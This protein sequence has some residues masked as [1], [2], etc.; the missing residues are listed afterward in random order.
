MNDSYP[1]QVNEVSDDKNVAAFFAIDSAVM[2]VSQ[3]ATSE[4][5]V[6][7]KRKRRTK[8]EMEAD[9]AAS[10]K[11]AEPVAAPVDEEEGVSVADKMI[12][13]KP[14]HGMSLYCHTQQKM[15]YAGFETL[16]LKDKW[17]ANQIRKG[18][19]VQV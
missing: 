18:V 13:V 9:R 5:P 4:P 14:R 2:T 7:V 12:R 19:L 16:I 1:A 6:P 17:I 10:V 15:I 11:A 3:G 8:A